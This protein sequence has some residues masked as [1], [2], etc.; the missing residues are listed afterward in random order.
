MFKNP[1]KDKMDNFSVARFI[2]KSTKVGCHSSD[3]MV[4]EMIQQY[5]SDNDGMLTLRD[6]LQFYY[7]AASDNVGDRRQAC[8]RNLKN[9]NVRPDLVKLSDVKDFALFRSKHMMPRFALQANESQYQNLWQLLERGD[10]TCAGTWE[11]IRMLATNEK[12][13]MEVIRM[14]NVTDEDGEVDWNAFF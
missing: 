6:F 13:Y 1:I 7:D 2:M 4:Q 3:R 8:F 5:D 10:E 9:L 11:L 12:Q 14:N